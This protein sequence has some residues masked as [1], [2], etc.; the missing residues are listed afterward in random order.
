MSR[1]ASPLVTLAVLLAACSGVAPSPST[2]DLTDAASATPSETRLIADCCW[3]RATRARAAFDAATLLGAMRDSRRPGGVP[4]QLETELIAATLAETLWTFGGKPWT[5]W[6]S[7]GSCGAQ[8]CTL[9][10][11]RCPP[12]APG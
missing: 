7:A 2:P 8:T 11:C 1:R 6:P 4:D 9:E 12:G 3:R 5:T 10:V